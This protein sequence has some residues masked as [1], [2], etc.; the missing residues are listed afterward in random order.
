MPRR[1]KDPPAG[2]DPRR[3]RNPG[4]AEPRPRDG[5]EA[6]QPAPPPQ[7]TPDEPGIERDPDPPKA[8]GTTRR[9]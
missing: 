5:A 1:D 8:P 2:A 6:H 9:H 4:Y 7:P 3:G